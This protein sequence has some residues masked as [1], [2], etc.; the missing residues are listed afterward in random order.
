[1]HPSWREA[2]TE[3]TAVFA[4]LGGAD[5]NSQARYILDFLADGARGR[6]LVPGGVAEQEMTLAQ[7]EQLTQFTQMA[8]EGAVV[9]HI[10]GWMYFRYLPLICR[11]GVFIVRPETE[12]LVDEVLK[13]LA[14]RAKAQTSPVTTPP[15]ILDLC[16]G[17]G[18]IAL[19]LVQE[20]AAE[21]WAVEI[22]DQAFALAND[23]EKYLIDNK[24]IDRGVNWVKGDVRELARLLPQKLGY[25]D[26]VV[27][28]PPYVPADSVV[29]REA[30][31]DPALALYGGGS[32]G[33]DLPRIIIEQAFSLLHDGGVL[34]ME[35]CPTQSVSLREQASEGGYKNA[36]TGT[37]LT[38][39][40]RFLCARRPGVILSD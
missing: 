4:R 32:A 11:P 17:S 12:V 1:M 6:G 28:N 31:Q 16:T 9:Q 7:Q 22:D 18:A 19:S 39:K 14:T 8:K 15:R 13:H 38:N 21:V 29:Q 23:N 30:R 20:T 34:I 25:F 3:L 36:Y 10:T 5:P 40:D 2:L 26:V 35:H 27:S 37:D 33:L 24:L